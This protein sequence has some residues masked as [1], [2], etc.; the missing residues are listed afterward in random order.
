MDSLHKGRVAQQTQQCTQLHVCRI[1][2]IHQVLPLLI[3]IQLLRSKG[4]SMKAMT[5]KRPGKHIL[6]L[7]RESRYLSHL[8]LQINSINAVSTSLLCSAT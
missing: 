1:C 4:K 2:S 6:L 7:C 8:S 3:T 5:I